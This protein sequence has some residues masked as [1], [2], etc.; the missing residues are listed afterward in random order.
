MQNSTHVSMQELSVAEVQVVAGGAFDDK[1]WASNRP[2][3]A[4]AGL[5]RSEFYSAA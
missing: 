2:V 3:A 4:A 1:W 5:S